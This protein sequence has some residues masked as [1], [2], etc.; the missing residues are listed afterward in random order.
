MRDGVVN[1]W[2]SINAR[3]YENTNQWLWVMFFF[4]GD[5]RKTIVALFVAN[6]HLFYLHLDIN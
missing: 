2:H 6:N 3:G 5:I 1:N 4:M